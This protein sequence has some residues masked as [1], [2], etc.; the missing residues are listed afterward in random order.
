MAH[1]WRWRPGVGWPRTAWLRRGEAWLRLEEWMNF[2]HVTQD[3]KDETRAYSEG[4]AGS[5][6]P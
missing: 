1:W 6:Q 2:L 3:L 4:K 5:A